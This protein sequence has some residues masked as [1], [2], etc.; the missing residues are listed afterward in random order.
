M[1]H[2][3]FIQSEYKLFSGLVIIDACKTYFLKKHLHVGTSYYANTCVCCTQGHYIICIVRCNHCLHK[4]KLA[5][6]K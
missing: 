6:L 5:L 2:H 1:R 3:F 4:Q